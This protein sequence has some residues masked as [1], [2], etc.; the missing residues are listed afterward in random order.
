MARPSYLGPREGGRYF[1]QIRLGKPAASLYGGPI[2]R[3]SLRTADF[4]EARKR[5]LETIGSVLHDRLATY[6]GRPPVASE[7]TLAER[8]AF[9]HQ[10][11]HY[12][13]R[14]KRGFSFRRR[15][16]VSRASGLISSTRTRCS[17]KPSGASASFGQQR[18]LG[19]TRPCAT[20]YSS[21]PQCAGRRRLIPVRT[22]LL[23]PEA[24]MGRDFARN[25]DHDQGAL[26]VRLVTSSSTGPSTKSVVPVPAPP[27]SASI[28]K[29]SRRS[30]ATPSRMRNYWTC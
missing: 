9:E 10:V 28:H 24:R 3:A 12:I 18:R 23:C 14:A 22:L 20:G 2:L 15:F 16:P 4:A 30:L 7:R 6:V 27:S 17:N 26:Q 5:L 13:G 1:M 8:C 21:S 19:Q 25:G 29:I 11:R